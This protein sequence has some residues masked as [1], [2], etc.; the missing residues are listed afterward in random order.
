MNS[1]LTGIALVGTLAAASV[2]AVAV[3]P[4]AHAQTT[5]AAAASL[6]Y[7]PPQGSSDCEGREVVITQPGSY[8][9]VGEC[10][11]ITVDA[12]DVRLDV[13]D[14]LVGDLADAGHATVY[15]NDVAGVVNVGSGSHYSLQ[16]AG[17]VNVYGTS[18][19]IRV[20]GNVP[21][22]TVRGDDN[23]VEVLSTIGSLTT[24]GNGNRIE[25]QHVVEA[26]D[27]GVNNSLYLKG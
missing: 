24:P 17:S 9:L 19:Y 22:V 23:F 10:P 5:T 16:R 26:S 7:E 25:A 4:S 8:R 1:T 6:R 12:V 18:A 11:S 13:A 15:G 14:A 3:A 21:F 2:G 27:H 20:Y